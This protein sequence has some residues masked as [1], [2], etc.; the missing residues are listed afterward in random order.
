[1][2]IYLD[3]FINVINKSKIK[4]NVEYFIDIER[5]VNTRL[6]LTFKGIKLSK[7]I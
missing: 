5:L 6:M 3:N 2:I 1:M 7:Y 4:E